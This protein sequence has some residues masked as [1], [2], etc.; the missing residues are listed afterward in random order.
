MTGWLA[1]PNRP[2]QSVAIFFA[3]PVDGQ[4]S[5][6]TLR[7]CLLCLLFPLVLGRAVLA[8]DSAPIAGGYRP[9][10]V[11]EEGV[12]AAARFAVE[13]HAKSEPTKLLKIV[14]AKQQVVAGMNYQLTLQVWQG[15]ST[16]TAVATVYVDL[17]A[18]KH[19]TDWQGAP[20]KWRASTRR[21][22]ETLNEEK[23]LGWTLSCNCRHGAPLPCSST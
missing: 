5:M 2:A 23:L 10:K 19:L 12:V 20:G 22:P 18:E 4:N 7:F 15:G 1:A 14:A 6:R 8:A 17:K 9:A 11:T 3:L 21:G 13:K 16:H